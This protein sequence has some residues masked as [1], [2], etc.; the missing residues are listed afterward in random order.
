MELGSLS[1]S[2]E[3][4]IENVQPMPYDRITL[5]ANDLA[6]SQYQHHPRAE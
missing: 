2:L 1:Q 3:P 4:L 6:D 5:G